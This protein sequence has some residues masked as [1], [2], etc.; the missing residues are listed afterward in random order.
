MIFR[1][2]SNENNSNESQPNT[3]S[4]KKKKPANQTTR[5]KGANA[6]KPKLTLPIVASTSSMT[7]SIPSSST[8]STQVPLSAPII[9]IE[10]GLLTSSSQQICNS[11]KTTNMLTRS[12]SLPMQLSTNNQD[13]H[14]TSEELER[15]LESRR[16][17]L[18][19]LM[20]EKTPLTVPVELF[21]NESSSGL[22]D[23]EHFIQ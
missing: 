12:T 19:M 22:P 1:K 13:G 6:G 10:P 18:A 20:P 8:S 9:K 16:Q 21:S 11:T 17:Q 23:N 14:M 2:K 3:S 5:S 15:H 4:S 7:I